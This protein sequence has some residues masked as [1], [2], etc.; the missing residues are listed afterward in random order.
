MSARPCLVLPLLALCLCAAPQLA[1]AT[2]GTAAVAA[3]PVEAFKTAFLDAY[4][5]QNPDMAVAMGNYRYADR[6]PAPDAV[7]RK[8]DLAFCDR[9][10]RQLKAV[11]VPSLSAQDRIDLALI[12]NEL[13]GNRWALTTFRSFEWNP[14]QYN[15]AGGF[16]LLLSTEYAPLE[17]RLRTVAKRLKGV[18]AYYAAAKASLGKPTL[19]HTAMAIA[20]SRGAEGVFGPDFIQKVEGSKLSPVEKKAL[21]AAALQAQRAIAGYRAFLQGLESRLKTGGARPFRVGKE[22]YE[23]QFTYAIQGDCN[24]E[25][26]YRRALVDKEKLLVKM[27]ELATQLWPAYFGAEPAP[28]DRLERI[29]RMIGKLSAKHVAADQF[30][31]EIRRQLPILER[32]VTEHNLVELDPTRPLEVRETPAYSR[33]I[34]GASFDGPGPYNPSAKGFYNVDPIEGTPEQ[35]E[36]FLREY[37]DYTLQVLNIHEAIPG[38]YVQFLHA[39]KSPSLVKAVFVNGAMAEGWAV[40]AERMMLESGYGGNSPEMWLMYSKWNL[41]VV[42][43]TILDYGVHVQGMTEAEAR[44]LLVREAFQEETEFKEKWHRVQVSSVQLSSYYAGYS[45]IRE[46]RE[47]VKAR[48]KDRFDLKAFHEELL[49]YGGAPV[50][51]LRELMLP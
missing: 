21:L 48:R 5:R 15:V 42:C 9:W 22:L 8:A 14:T 17:T 13:E 47:D 32:W 1:G 29:G 20:Q 40:Y 24:G 26:L 25:Q 12:R 43:N 34:G 3:S 51:F 31:T 7:A 36:S 19:E 16:D 33:G 23:Q 46:L 45:A 30:M 35:K 28:A 50:R 44:Q 6:L 39:N 27:D 10:L 11:D 4:W 2:P 41:R 18:P 49:G 38:H 37:N